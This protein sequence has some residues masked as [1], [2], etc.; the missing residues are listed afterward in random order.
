MAGG[1]SPVPP[2]PTGGIPLAAT[3]SST[4][5]PASP[6]ARLAGSPDLRGSPRSSVDFS[7]VSG[8]PL[9]R[10]T[11]SLPDASS[12]TDERPPQPPPLIRQISPLQTAK[13]VPTP[14]SPE[15][16]VEPATPDADAIGATPEDAEAENEA[17]IA[18]A[19]KR[20]KRGARKKTPVV[21]PADEVVAAPPPPPTVVLPPPAAPKPSKTGFGRFRGAIM[22][23]N[24]ELEALRKVR[25]S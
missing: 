19:R 22:N 10:D 8:S 9:I 20:R 3:L 15:V 2:T 14:S 5:I 7:S 23:G 21:A 25:R 24:P 1:D 18:A 12:P 17:I 4:H 6:L 16:T 13:Y 11:M